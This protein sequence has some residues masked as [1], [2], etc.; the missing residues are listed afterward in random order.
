MRFP[1]FVLGVCL[2]VLGSNHARSEFTAGA[3]SV[4]ITPPTLPV[5]V[6]GGMLSRTVGDVKS[7]LH[8][9]ALAFA[10]Q[11]GRVAI[12]VVD[13]CMM[14][15][16]FLDEVKAHAS[17]QT[18]IAAE[19]ILISATHTHSAP[20]SMGCLGTEI[21]PRYVPFLR[22]R[23]VEAIAAAQ[24]NL[25]PARIGWASRNAASF[26]AL[27]RWIRRP[28]RVAAD[29]FGNLTVRANTHAAANWDDVTGESGPEDPEL[30]LISVQA[31]NGRPIAVLANSSMHYFGQ[32]GLG[33]DYFGR[34]YEGLEERIGAQ[35][36]ADGPRFV[37][38][39]SQGCSG[40]IWRVDYSVPRDEIVFFDRAL[41]VEEVRRLA[42]TGR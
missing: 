18:G 24:R 11:R 1:A 42:L 25:E 33:A 34:F 31:L 36:E 17:R 8:A 39:L 32:D 14:S 41:T 15:R 21:D 12:V 5:I 29:P 22:D 2:V 19:R 30:T 26:T 13:S 23:I 28:D 9:R 6:N 40:D 37:A 4:D 10:D 20:S 35:A 3:A 7:R 38:I 16:P 27:R